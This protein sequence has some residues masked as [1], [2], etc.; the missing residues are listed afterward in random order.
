MPMLADMTAQHRIL[1]AAALFSTFMLAGCARNR[2]EACQPYCMPNYCCVPQQP[3]CCPCATCGQQC[4]GAPSCSTCGTSCS[5]CGGSCTTCGMSDMGG[6]SS[7]MGSTDPQPM[8][9]P[10]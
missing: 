8:P 2:R 9:Q 10:M 7:D 3:V 1:L 6:M 5:T 4:C